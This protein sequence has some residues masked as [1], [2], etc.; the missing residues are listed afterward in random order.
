MHWQLTKIINMIQCPKTI[1]TRNYWIKS[2][3]FALMCV[4]KERCAIRAQHVIGY[5]LPGLYYIICFTMLI[6]PTLLPLRG[7]NYILYVPNT[8]RNGKSP[9]ALVRLFSA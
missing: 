6:T 5:Y 2:H 4:I 9:E 7:C 3:F 8:L 1:T